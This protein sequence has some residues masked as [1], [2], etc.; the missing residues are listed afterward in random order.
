LL[1]AW[2][3]D[4][5]GPSI[6]SPA[7][8]ILFS[9]L[10]MPTAALLVFSGTFFI[11]YT[12]QR[13][14]QT[15]ILAKEAAERAN[16]AK[17]QFLAKMSHEI[18]TPM[19]GIISM[20]Q[21]L[22]RS[23]TNPEQQQ[24]TRIIQDSGTSLLTVIN[25][26]LDFSKIEDGKVRLEPVVFA[27]R[28]TANDVMNLL[29]CQAVEKGLEFS[30][31]CDEQVPRMVRGDRTRLW[32]ILLNLVGNAV[33]FTHQGQVR[34]GI[35]LV[36]KAGNACLIRI[37]IRD[38]GIGI[39]PKDRE[40]LFR[41][42][43]QA[44]DSDTRRFGG[45]GLGLAISKQLVELMGGEIGYE[46]EPGVGSR[47]WFTIRVEEETH[48]N[49]PAEVPLNGGIPSVARLQKQAP[50]PETI[51]EGPVAA[52]SPLLPL[53]LAA[54]DNRSN[55]K[56]IRILLEHMGLRTEFAATGAQAVE[57]WKLRRHGLILMDC[58]MPEMDGYSATREIRKL[59]EGEGRKTRIIAMTAEAMGD[60][61]R[62]CLDA[63]MDEYISKP[64]LAGEFESLVTA[65]LKVAPAPEA[66]TSLTPG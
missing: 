39:H 17:S 7:Q 8:I 6:L 4:A 20:S 35:S 46:S 1:Q 60:S 57:A 12:N 42:F 28:N 66:R 33:K 64:F 43:S 44:D 19:N 3:Y 31:E 45:T 49:P 62:K 27:L 52:E 21:L 30:W 59:E 40:G 50:V 54:E 53:I 5:L 63:G 18:R 58:Q 13:N 38:T 11:Y 55:Q 56:V 29:T 34:L 14:E 48:S 41:P 25:Q 2:G 24:Y 36:E 10:I 23:A 15:L 37:V 32:Q 61:R 16:Q 47:F 26:I 22:S 51:P 9:D 65:M